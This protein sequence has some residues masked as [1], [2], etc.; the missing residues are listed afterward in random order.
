MNLTHSWSIRDALVSDAKSIIFV[1][2]SAV[3]QT[4]KHSYEQK[5][6]DEWSP[7]Q[8]LKREYLMQEK[9]KNNTEG[10]IMLVIELNG[11]I[12]GFGEI[13]PCMHELK[14]VY[15]DPKFGRMGLGAAL[16]KELEL[17][18]I[19]QG[20]VKLTLHASLNAKNFYLK[21]G[22]VVDT[23]GHHKLASGTLMPC[24]FMSKNLA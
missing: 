4:A 6:L 13:L 23:D 9:L 12:A 17:R 15:I 2:Q 22:Y 8:S 24:I 3:H 16:L 10:A 14:A 19:K 11:Q 21:N 5:I 1:H 7:I 20:L 18:A